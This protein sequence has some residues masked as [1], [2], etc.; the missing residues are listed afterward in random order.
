MSPH[1]PTT[2]S[3]V[4]PGTVDPD[5]LPWLTHPRLIHASLATQRAVQALTSAQKDYDEIMQMYNNLR[6]IEDLHPLM[7]RV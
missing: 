3:T 1:T 6:R 2:L 7:A 5:D 4:S